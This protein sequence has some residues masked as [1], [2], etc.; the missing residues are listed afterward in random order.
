[1]LECDAVFGGGHMVDLHRLAHLYILV[2][3][4]VAAFGMALGE[5][6]FALLVSIALSRRLSQTLAQS[7]STKTEP[8]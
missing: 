3:F 5:V 7:G 8:V 4:I 6:T 2:I 1:M